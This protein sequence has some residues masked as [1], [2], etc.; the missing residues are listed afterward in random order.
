MR[1]AG[2]V[3]CMA[4]VKGPL[5]VDSS[6][7]VKIHGV[8]CNNVHLSYATMNSD[9]QD[10]ANGVILSECGNNTPNDEKMHSEE[11]KPNHPVVHCVISKTNFVNAAKI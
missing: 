10:S 3:A 7:I 8:Q 5:C 9:I 6:E 11:L 4:V 1:W 2:H